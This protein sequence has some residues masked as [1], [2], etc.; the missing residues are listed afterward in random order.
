MNHKITIQIDKPDVD[1]H[2]EADLRQCAK[3]L[4]DDLTDQIMK[5]IV[6]H[7]QSEYVNKWN[8]I[9]HTWDLDRLILERKQVDAKKINPK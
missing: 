7:E 8:K 5:Q 6:A 1:I 9:I 2:N 4:A 3:I